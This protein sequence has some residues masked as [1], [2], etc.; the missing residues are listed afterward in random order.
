[1]HANSSECSNQ[2]CSVQQRR[3]RL[4]TISFTALLC[5]LLFVSLLL[6]AAVRMRSAPAAS[7]RVP[8]AIIDVQL[9]VST[10]DPEV[11]VTAI[12]LKALSHN[13]TMS[14]SPHATAA[15]NHSMPIVLDIGMNAGRFTLLS[16]QLGGQVVAIEP[17]PA[18]ISSTSRQLQQQPLSVMQRV[19]ILNAAVGREPGVLQ[20]LLYH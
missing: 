12:F 17:Q 11:Q 2:R 18:C 14:S 9:P 13:G 6:A 4:S 15:S 5:L 20:V 10:E 19:T 8:A 1:M 7:V 16:A 3:P